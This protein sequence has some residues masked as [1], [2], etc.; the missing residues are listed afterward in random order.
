MA[1]AK[2]V[3]TAIDF[4]KARDFVYNNGILWER[5][6]FAYLFQNGSLKRLHHSLQSYQNE[7]G[8]YGNAFEHDL[9]CPNSN[10]LAL[11]FLLGM[12]SVNGVPVG[13]ILDGTAAWLERNRNPDGSLRNP[14]ETLDYPH[15]PWWN[16]GGQSIPDSIVGNL[17]RQGKSTPDL[18]TSTAKWVQ[19]N[20]TLEKIRA[21]D[22]LFM[23]YHPYDYYFALPDPELEP[24]R[25]AT[26]EKIIALG[27]TV[28][29]DQ[30]YNLVC[31]AMMPTSPVAQAAPD[32][33]AKALDYLEQAQQEDGGWNDQHGIPHWRPYVTIISL[34]ALRNHGRNIGV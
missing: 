25:Q 17:I 10:P 21:T 14:P 19:T 2:T 23:A 28:P 34:L 16:E 31:F 13:T 6:L 26:I 20:L 1:S 5:D 11:E 33:I 7:D 8:G 30:Y 18:N 29:A 22:W 24:F 12:L 4:T 15:A 32:L 9:R 3:K 27:R